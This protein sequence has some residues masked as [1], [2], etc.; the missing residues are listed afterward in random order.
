MTPCYFPKGLINHP[1][2]TQ[3]YPIFL[4]EPNFKKKIH[5]PVHCLKMKNNQCFL[6]SAEN[7]INFIL[8]V[9]NISCDLFALLPVSSTV[10]AFVK[11]FDVGDWVMFFFRE[12]AVEYTSGDVR[13]E[14]ILFHVQYTKQNTVFYSCFWFNTIF[15]SSLSWYEIQFH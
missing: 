4:K 6:E 1:R 12:V 3:S 10:P 14:P 5:L 2:N 9:K 13:N 8:V 7:L 15:H 11:S